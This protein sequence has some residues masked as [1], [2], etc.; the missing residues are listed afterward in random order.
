MFSN[1]PN[2]ICR[3][4]DLAYTRSGDKGN[5]CNIGVI[6]RDRFF[7]VS[8]LNNRL[9]SIKLLKGLSHQFESGN[10]WYGWKEQK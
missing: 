3:L 1:L 9:G 2:F 10:K 7:H 6:A 8:L 5:S 4:D